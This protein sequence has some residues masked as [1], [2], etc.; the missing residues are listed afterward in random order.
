M[1][2]IVGLTFLKSDHSNIS[3]S[4]PNAIS[5]SLIHIISCSSS[6]QKLM[7]KGTFI[8]FHPNSSRQQNH[9]HS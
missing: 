3:Q 2:W 5:V 7:H 9:V 6:F 4:S 1:S 8:H